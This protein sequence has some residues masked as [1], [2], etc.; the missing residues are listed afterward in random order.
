MR[1]EIVMIYIEH[2]LFF[3]VVVLLALVLIVL[4]WRLI[5]RLFAFF[6]LLMILWYILYLA[7]IVSSPYT[8]MREYRL[9]EKSEN[10]TPFVQ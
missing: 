10:V 1:L 9:R 7:G 8:T 5:V 4:T 2:F 6:A 3:P